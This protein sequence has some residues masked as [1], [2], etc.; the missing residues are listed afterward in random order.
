VRVC[1]HVGGVTQVVILS[2]A[3][4]LATQPASWASPSPSRGGPC[5]GAGVWNA[6]I[7][8]RDAPS[9]SAAGVMSP[10]VIQRSPAPVVEV[11]EVEGVRRLQ[12]RGGMHAGMGMH[13]TRCL[14]ESASVRLFG[15]PTARSGEHQVPDFSRGVPQVRQQASAVHQ[16]EMVTPWAP[17]ATPL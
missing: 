3:Q 10:I 8:C 14:C 5:G 17:H 9:A 7:P 15:N 4:A 13:A 16:T 2:P 11:E 6:Y 12:R 1:V